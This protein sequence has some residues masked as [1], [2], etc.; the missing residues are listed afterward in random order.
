MAKSKGK[1]GTADQG[2]ERRTSWEYGTEFEHCMRRVFGKKAY[3]IAGVCTDEEARRKWVGKLLE[4]LTRDAQELDTTQE[5]RERISYLIEALRRERWKGDDASWHL[6]FDL[7][8]VLAEMMGYHGLRGERPYTPM[9]WQSLRAHLDFGN[10]RGKADE[11]H[12]E[13]I[14]AARRRREVVKYLKS[15]GLTD[16][17]I[18]MVLKTSEYE[19]KKLK[20]NI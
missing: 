5:H 6:V 18:A 4:Q 10:A 14:T 3:H 7:L 19:V 20:R 1:K 12:E 2:K 8:N 16:F 11:L 15:Q 13:L 9:Y 17:D